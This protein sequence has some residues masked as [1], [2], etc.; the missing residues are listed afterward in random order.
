MARRRALAAFMLLVLSAYPALIRTNRSQPAF[1]AKPV[2]AGVLPGAT[3]AS[4]EREA[5]QRWLRGMSL[6][7]K[8]AQLV[9]ITSYGEAPSSRSAAYREFVR[10]VRDLKVG[11]L[12]VIN[13]V[14]GGA[15][16]SAEPHAMASFLNRM[17][18]LAKVPL[19]VGADFERGAS[20][21]VTGT[22]K[23]PHLM[24]YGA[25]NDL[26]LT[27][28]LGAATAREARALGVHW[29]FAPVADVNSNPDNPIINIRS[30]G[31]NPVAVAS[32]VEAFIRGAHSD[33]ANR[34]LVTAK[35]FP[36]HGDTS[37]D[38]HMGLARLDA[39]RTRMN[40]IELVPF[41]G[42]V[43]ARVDAVMTAHMAVPAVEEEEIPA[44][45][46]KNVIT[47]LLRDDL[48]FSGLI[49][50]DAMDMQGLTRQFPG[51]EAAIRALQAG[52]D[53][54]LMPG[55]PE[56]VIKTV[57]AAVRDG[58][59]SRKR[60]DESVLRVLAAKARVGLDR[61]RLVD[62]EQIGDI[63][64]S[65][66]FSESAQL[67]AD[68]AVTVIRN[69]RQSLPLQDPE[70]AC[71]YVLTESRYGQQGRRLIDEVRT[72]S[73]KLRTT[74]LD[75]QISKTEMEQHA[76]SAADCVTVIAAVFVTAA[77]YRGNVALAGEYP[78]LVQSLV[79]GRAPVVMI[80]L[81]SP[82]LLRSFPQVSSYL[83]TFSPAVTAETAAVKALFGEIATTARL[84][85]TIPGAANYGD[86]I[87]VAA[88]NAAP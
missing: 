84:P 61:R 37:V 62:V 64:D 83:A 13:R 21:R 3:A 43:N 46:S 33:T 7:Q 29:V 30:F 58:R 67:A 11:G 5:A 26:E 22:A 59:L 80:A 6:Q 53:V 45:V 27:R 70:H 14:V 16:R 75:P 77:A 4:N 17:Q 15:V 9:V 49:V 18:R 8:V 23:F 68:K 12:I 73:K 42:A 57:V 10:A 48:H 86:G 38:S 31:E 24:A 20:M 79:S 51:T 72:R 19:L 2:N 34:V 32:H 56:A 69:D 44:T 88:R 71:L 35:H 50:T 82:Y 41:R 52:V 54:L 47:G 63:I 25:A 81:G 87:T 1:A 36:G 74:L 85:V 66:E 78:A 76:E 28:S 60:I 65:P 55:N 39:D 40:A